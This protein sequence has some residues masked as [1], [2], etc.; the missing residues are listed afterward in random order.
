MPSN[1]RERRTRRRETR[2]RR[3]SPSRLSSGEDGADRT[4]SPCRYLP[5]RCGGIHAF[6]A[7]SAN[8]R[9]GRW[10]SDSRPQPPK[11]GEAAML[12]ISALAVRDSPVLPRALGARASPIPAPPQRRERCHI[13]HEPADYAT[14]ADR[15]DLAALID[16]RG[17]AA[18]TAA[19][20][21]NRQALGNLF[22]AA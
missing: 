17:Y 16:G 5:Y 15:D 21:L 14:T 7:R 10:R 6:G 22:R 3:T 19:D 11:Y 13:A 2:Q 1:V 12:H 8:G 18:G 9:R 20:V 4:P